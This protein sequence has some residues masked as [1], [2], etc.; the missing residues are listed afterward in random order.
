MWVD[1]T[2]ASCAGYTILRT[3]GW[4][5]NAVVKLVEKDEQLYAMKMFKTERM[6]ESKTFIEFIR[7]EMEVVEGLNLDNVPRYYEFKEDYWIKRNGSKE[8]VFI[9]V[10]EHVEGVTLFDFFIKMKKQEDK[11]LRYIFR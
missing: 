5:G 10:M 1:K 4:G 6:S 9:L 7:R 11:F 2:E 8:K 3:L